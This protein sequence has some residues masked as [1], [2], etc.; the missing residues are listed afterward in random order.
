[1]KT[2]ID[3]VMETSI[4]LKRTMSTS[5]AIMVSVG[6]TI[7]TG[8]FLNSGDVISTAG[9][10]GAIV[11]Y[12]MTSC[13]GELAAAMPVAGSLQAYSTEFIS[14][15]MGFTIGWVNWSGGANIFMYSVQSAISLP[16]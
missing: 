10:G 13:L 5:S 16:M 9:P 1:K 14:P 4:G 2:S 11:M 3:R 6:G 15:A 12:L 8:L 7:G